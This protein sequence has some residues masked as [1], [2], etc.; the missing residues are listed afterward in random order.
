MR[1]S[2]LSA[3]SVYLKLNLMCACALTTDELIR[4][5]QKHKKVGQ[6]SL[7]CDGV[8]IDERI[9]RSMLGSS[10]NPGKGYSVL[11]WNL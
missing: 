3:E 7:G 9:I 8:F 5:G 1:Q 10:L 2:H 6:G 4:L 11:S